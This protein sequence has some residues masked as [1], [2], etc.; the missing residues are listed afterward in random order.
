MRPNVT[1]VTFPQSDAADAGTPSQDEEIAEFVLDGERRRARLHDYADLYNVPGLYETLI[2]DKLQCRSPSRVVW[3]L[4]D[5]LTDLEIPMSD[6]R[7]LDV[8]AGNGVVGDELVAAGAELVV[9]LDII[10]EARTAADRDRPEV[11]AD[12]VVADLLDL[13]EADEKTLRRM[14]LNALV[15]VGA[16]GFGDMPAP[17]FVKAMD[18]ISSEG[19]IAFNIEEGFFRGKRTTDFSNLIASL[20]HDGIIRYE[21]THRYRHR[22]S[23][24]GKP[25]HYIAVVARKMRDLPDDIMDGWV[26]SAADADAT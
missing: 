2:Y 4:E 13:S 10:P 17:A 9:G 23:V 15:L 14:R 5:V 22:I 11:Y 3:L 12:Y 16:L 21:A 25:I 19:W 8:G 6:L 1:D 18:L 24:A 20:N 7:V 26:E